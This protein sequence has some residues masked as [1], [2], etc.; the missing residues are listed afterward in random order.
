MSSVYR[1][2]WKR[3]NDEGLARLSQSNNVL[4][5]QHLL[6]SHRN[7]SCSKPFADLY[8][9]SAFSP[10]A[11]LHRTRLLSTHANCNLSFNPGWKKRWVSTTLKAVTHGSVTPNFAPPLPQPTENRTCPLRSRDTL[12]RY[13]L[14]C[15]IWMSIRFICRHIFLFPKSNKKLIYRRDSARHRS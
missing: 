14:F 2:K 1:T 5:I 7:I 4:A 11:L 10:S 13:S 15:C 9:P 12:L 8:L 3:Q 6:G